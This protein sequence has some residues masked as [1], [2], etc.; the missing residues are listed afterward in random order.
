VTHR[1]KIL[2]ALTVV[3]FVVPNVMFGTFIGREGLDMGQFIG[4][5]FRTLPAAQI[6]VDILLVAATFLLWAGW[7]SQRVGIERWW[8]VFP[9]TFL[10]GLCFGAPLFLLLRERALRRAAV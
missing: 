5:P 8:L 2:L 4:D 3:G 10:V 6:T 7:E 9:A 1:E